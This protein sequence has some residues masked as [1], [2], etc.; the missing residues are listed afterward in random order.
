MFL[1]RY[2]LKNISVKQL[3]HNIHHKL[4]PNRLLI[5]AGHRVTP[6]GPSAHPELSRRQQFAKKLKKTLG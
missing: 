2:E 5:K 1:Q 3:L 6:P 4:V